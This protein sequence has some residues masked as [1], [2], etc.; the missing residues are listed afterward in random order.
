MNGTYEIEHKYLIRMPDIEMLAGLPGCVRW[1]IH[2][3]YLSSEKGVTE[4]VRSIDQDGS[5]SWW[6]TTKKRISALTSDEAEVGIAREEYDRL[7]NRADPGRQ[8]IVKTRYR[9][10]FRGQLLEVDVYPFWKDRAILEVEVSDEKQAVLFPEWLQ[11]IREVTADKRYKN[12]HLAKN[13]P[14]DPIE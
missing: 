4:R 13:I 11:V 7:L 2:Q 1:K 14:M 8:T 10:P 3:T 9:I 6:H 5:M 12:A